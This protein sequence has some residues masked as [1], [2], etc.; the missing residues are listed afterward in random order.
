MKVPTYHKFG[1]TKAQIEKS[2]SRDKKIS[3]ILTHH[4]TVGIG[5]AFGLVIYVIYFNKVRPD[6]FIQI[7][8]QVSLFASLGVICVGVP[9]VLFKLA[10]MFY[11]KKIKHK[12]VEHKTI[13]AYREERD[14]FD[15]W[16]LRKD[17]SFWKYLD[18]LSF[19][20]EIMNIYMHLGYEL[21]D[22]MF[23]EENPNDRIIHNEE[24][25][26]YL[27]FN[28]LHKEISETSKIDEL[29][30]RMQEH[31]CDE[32]LVFSQQGFNKK[33]VTYSADK[34]LILFDIN[35]L[36]KLARTVKKQTDRTQTDKTEAETITEDLN[37]AEEINS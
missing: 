34:P 15:F 7:V 33:V 21:K 11:F 9:A 36:V 1:L 18:G 14:E 24:K 23:S 4:L 35:G 27:S 31:N 16:K 12:T 26:Y 13:M 25:N 19:E 3:D 17:Y 5:I 37:L 28:T 30:N 10:E 20:K 2:E 29:V 32:L 8:M 22:D 6:T